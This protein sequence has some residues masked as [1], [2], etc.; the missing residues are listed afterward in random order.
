[1]DE[2]TI[3]MKSATLSHY[4]AIIKILEKAGPLNHGELSPSILLE[5]KTLDSALVFLAA[6][7]LIKEMPVVGGESAG[8]IITEKGFRVLNFLGSN[9]SATS[10]KN[11]I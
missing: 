7:N 8:Y 10:R 4:L 6:Q 9:L 1:V 5:P 3:S 2:A 11:E